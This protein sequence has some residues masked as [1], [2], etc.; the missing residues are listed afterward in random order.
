MFN[1]NSVAILCLAVIFF[2]FAWQRRWSSKSTETSKLGFQSMVEVAR[3]YSQMEWDGNKHVFKASLNTNLG[4]GLP[5]KIVLQSKIP[6][7]H[8]AFAIPMCRRTIF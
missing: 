2:K 8:S 3:F 7:F 5:E 6:A 4:S 1:N